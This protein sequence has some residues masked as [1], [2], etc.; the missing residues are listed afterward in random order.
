MTGAQFMRPLKRLL[1][2]P[3]I[4]LGKLGHENLNDLLRHVLRFAALHHLLFLYHVSQ[5]RPGRR[6]RRGL[7]STI[8]MRLWLRKLSE[9]PCFHIDV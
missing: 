2:T 8:A 7:T 9:R 4:V 1:R 5:D 6:W 3:R